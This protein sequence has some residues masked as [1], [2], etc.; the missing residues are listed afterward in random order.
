MARP[1]EDSSNQ[2]ASIGVPSRRSGAALV[3]PSRALAT[4]IDGTR[5]GCRCSSGDSDFEEKEKGE[6]EDEDEDQENE[7]DAATGLRRV[8]SGEADEVDE[9]RSASAAS[10][11]SRRGATV[12]GWLC[13]WY[14]LSIGLTM[15]NRWLFALYDFHFPLLVTAVHLGI[16][17]P[18]ARGA[19]ALLGLAPPVLTSAGAWRHLLTRVAPTGVAT[20]LDISL[21][22]L[23]LLHLS[24][25]I[26]TNANYCG[27]ERTTQLDP[28][29]T[30]PTAAT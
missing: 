11:L 28:T 14:L 27:I 5:C 13:V 16:K 12:A 10:V 23:A 15:Y 3:G 6:D 30:P 21:S 8:P 19:M 25:T 17:A 9:A 2:R 4:R 7:K 18:A 24:V 26:Y 20:A 22:N 29:L 1:A